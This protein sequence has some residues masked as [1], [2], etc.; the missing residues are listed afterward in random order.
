M[1]VKN[2]YASQAFDHP[3]DRWQNIPMDRIKEIREAR[4]LTQAD[5][6]AMTGLNQ[7]YLSKVENGSANVSIDKLRIIAVALKVDLHEMFMPSGLK[8]RVL[9]AIGSMDDEE[10]QAAALVL[11]TMA[12]KRRQ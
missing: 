9:L 12:A 10:A 3:S 11:E 5:L 7:G 6:A 2:I 1:S 8:G 4:G